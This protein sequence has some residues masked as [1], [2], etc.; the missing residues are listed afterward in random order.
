MALILWLQP[1]YSYARLRS[2]TGCAA[3]KWSAGNIS[4]DVSIESA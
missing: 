3:D 4:C 1:I 2:I